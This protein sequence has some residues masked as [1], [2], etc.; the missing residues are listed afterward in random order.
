MASAHSILMQMVGVSDVVDAIVKIDIRSN[1]CDVHSEMDGLFHQADA[2]L[3]QL[4]SEY[5]DTFHGA[6]GVI[7]NWKDAP[8]NL[9]EMF[10]MACAVTWS[11]AKLVHSVQNKEEFLAVVKERHAGVAFSR[12]VAIGYMRFVIEDARA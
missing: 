1:R 6:S 10:A 12:M 8:V 11:L 4:A 7:A 3:M 9:E 2:S 5:Y